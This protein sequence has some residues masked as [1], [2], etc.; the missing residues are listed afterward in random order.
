MAPPIQAS[1]DFDTEVAA[2]FDSLLTAVHEDPESGA[3]RGRLGMAY[4][5]AN[6]REAALESFDQASVLDPGEPRWPFHAAVVLADLGKLPAAVQRMDAVIALEPDYAP[7]WWRRGEWLLGTG[8]FAAAGEA[9]RRSVELKPDHPGGHVGRA[10]VALKLRRPQEAADILEDALRNDPLVSFVPY[11]H[12]L[13]GTA[14]ARLGQEDRAKLHLAQGRAGRPAW[15]DRWSRELDEYRVS[16]NDRVR[17]A[18]KA[19]KGGRHDR[20][21]EILEPARAIYPEDARIV[22][23][24][25]VAYFNLGRVREAQQAL[26][27]LRDLDPGNAFAYLH[28]SS[29]YEAQQKPAQALAQVT[30][31]LE[32]NPRMARGHRRLGDLLDRLGRPEEAM[33]AYAEA[34]RL[35]PKDAELR[36]TA[37][38]LAHRQGRTEEAEAGYARAEEL[39]PGVFTARIARLRRNH[40]QEDGGDG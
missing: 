25:G 7:A 12:Q 20:V 40:G 22:E 30:R 28:L 35:E 26:E 10:R 8:E 36:L 3:A 19:A 9:F 21:V 11:I 33:A 13:L 38:A 14:Y 27:S 4:F 34:V 32:L 18:V 15:S 39:A 16:M 24:L 1:G 23:H 37:A 17:F 2:L 6:L 5:A 31:A 29:V